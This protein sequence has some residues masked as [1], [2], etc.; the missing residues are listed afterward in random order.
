MHYALAS[1]SRELRF[2]PDLSHFQGIRADYTF[3]LRWFYVALPIPDSGL[4]LHLNKSYPAKTKGPDKPV[5]CFLKI[6]NRAA[7]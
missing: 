7:G 1:G 3:A 5:L 6:Q 2:S 4:F